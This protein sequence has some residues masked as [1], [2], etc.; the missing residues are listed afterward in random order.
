MLPTAQCLLVSAH[1]GTAPHPPTPLCHHGIPADSSNAASNHPCARAGPLGHAW[2]GGL[3]W[4]VRNRLHL[5]P[6]S[7]A[8]LFA[9]LAA[10][11]FLFS[12]LHLA[13]F[14][15]FLTVGE[16]GGVGVRLR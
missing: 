11:T 6:N 9:K 2:Y 5:K 4:A 15:T 14:F 3:D 16:V 7:A 13:G 8:F 10:D 1:D 12:P